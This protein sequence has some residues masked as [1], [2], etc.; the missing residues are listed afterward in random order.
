M[1]NAAPRACRS[2]LAIALP[3]I[4]TAACSSLPAPPVALARCPPL[5][6]YSPEWQRAAAAELGALPA[7]SRLARALAD[8]ATLRA[9]CRAYAPPR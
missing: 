6:A 3:L 4:S 9:R 2:A 5:A 1:R 7:D 8:Y